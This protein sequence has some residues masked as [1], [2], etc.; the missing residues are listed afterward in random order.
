MWSLRNK[1]SEQRGKK[2]QTEEKK[3]KPRFLSIKKEPEGRGVGEG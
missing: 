2:R 3:N 1:V